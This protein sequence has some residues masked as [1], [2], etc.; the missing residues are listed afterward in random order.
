[1]DDSR[2]FF[3]ENGEEK[4]AIVNFGG[5]HKLYV[6]TEP[7]DPI[8][9][10]VVGSIDSPKDAIDK[11]FR[12]SKSNDDISIA[13]NGFPEWTKS[14]K[15]DLSKFLID[16]FG[17]SGENEFKI[18]KSRNGKEYHGTGKFGDDIKDISQHTVVS[19]IKA[20]NTISGC[21]ELIPVTDVDVI[22][23][24]NGEMIF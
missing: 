18:V 24:A 8:D 14:F 15:H 19:I 12:L 23:T 3:I 6:A 11:W 7:N 17:L 1:M 9:N 5:V 2:S 20:L 22:D 13:S 4:I 10:V 16:H 21:S